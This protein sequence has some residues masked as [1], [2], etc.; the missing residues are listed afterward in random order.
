MITFA[1]FRGIEEN[2]IGF[3]IDDR[4]GRSD[5]LYVIEEE[6]NRF[7]TPTLNLNR[8]MNLASTGTIM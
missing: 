4:R 6:P 1:E 8:N 2:T 7:D 5:L 3:L